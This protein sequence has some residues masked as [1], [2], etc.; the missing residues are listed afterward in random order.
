MGI[1]DHSLVYILRDRVKISRSS[2]TIKA[3]SYKNFND[4]L[5]CN[6]LHDLDWSNILQT[7]YIN[8]AATTFNN[9]LLRVLHKHAQILTRRM[10]AANPPWVNDEL[11]DA[12]RERDFRKKKAAKSGLLSDW[13]I[14]KQTRNTVTNLKN[15]LKRDYYQNKIIE[16][17]KNDLW[18]TIKNILPGGNQ[19]TPFPS[20][21]TNN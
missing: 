8:E 20:R 13:N 21:I 9:N 4:E 17:R 11:I 14:F 5:F 1:S 18:K 6:E 15:R 3:R 2:K 19:I 12:I 7:N 16:N 10:S